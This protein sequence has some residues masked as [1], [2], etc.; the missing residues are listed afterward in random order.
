MIVSSGGVA[1]DFVS[2]SS[3]AW[4]ADCR[5]RLAAMVKF[6]EGRP[7]AD[8][9][10]GYL[11]AA[12]G[13]G[14]WNLAGPTRYEDLSPANLTAFQSWAKTKY[15]NDIDALRAAWNDP[16]IIGFNH[17]TIPNT[18]SRQAA[19]LGPLFNPSLR[20]KVI[21][22]YEFWSNQVANRIESCAAAVKGAS[23]RKPLVGV[24]Y[25]YLFENQQKVEMGHAALHRLTQSPYLDYLSA[26]YS[27]VLRC[28]P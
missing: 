2:P 7:Y 25:G 27:Y 22:Y 18:A 9:V 1:S 8:H 3:M 6:I 20:R 21:D 28:R 13:G 19:D 26:P 5:K 4:D 24:F 12:Y 16:A 23:S 17:I 15:H 14:E 11:L 10:I